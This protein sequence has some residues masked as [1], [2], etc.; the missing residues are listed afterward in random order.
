M[1]DWAKEDPVIVERG[2]GC[3]LVDV[4]GNRYLDGVSSLWCNVHGHHVP[5]IDAAIRAQLDRIAHSTMLGLSATPAI[6]LAERL[7]EISPAGLSR[8]FYS[9]SGATAVEIA[10]KM[11]FQ[12][13]RHSGHP[14]RSLFVTFEGAYHGDTLGAV[15]LGGIDIFHKLF[16]PLLF[17]TLRATAPTCLRCP[18]GRQYPSCATACL[19]PLEQLLA[20]R[21]GEIAAVVIEPVIQGA[22]GMIVQPSG[23]LAR[24]RAACDRAGTLLICDEVAT[25]FG[26]TGAMFACETE[27][28]SPD[29]LTVAKGLTGGYLPLAATLTTELI[30]E[31]FLGEIEQTRTFFHGHTY[32]GNAL[33]CAAALASL[34]LFVSRDLLAHVRAMSARLAERL[35]PLARHPNVAEIR[36]RGLMVGVEIVVDRATAAPHPP[37]ERVPG[38][39]VRAARRR[40]V[41]LRPLGNVMVLMPPLAIPPEAIDL[42]VSVLTSSVEEVLPSPASS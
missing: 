35:A 36:Q 6:D 17:D 7:I 28:V 23:F 5:E 39:I 21:G 10:L 9:D 40:G 42:L 18:L 29:L 27:S 20:S 1:R 24:V 33:A 38:R 13:W 11:A 30:Y 41:I 4:D 14:E 25:G 37:A 34:D 22:A 3:W 19:E 31:A 2:D 26:R 16:Q 8:V 15:S 32:T 12:F